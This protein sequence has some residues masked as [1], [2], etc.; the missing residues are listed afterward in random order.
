MSDDSTSEEEEEVAEGNFLFNNIGPTDLRIIH[1]QL[2]DL[3]TG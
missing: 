2:D 3:F 1:T